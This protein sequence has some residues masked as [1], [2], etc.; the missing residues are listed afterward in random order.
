LT[1]FA[2]LGLF[3]LFEDALDRGGRRRWALAGAGLGVALLLQTTFILFGLVALALLLWRSRPR[4]REALRPA[5]VAAGV[6]LLCLTPAF[7]RNVAVG[8]PVFGLSAVGPVTFIASNVPGYDPA[9][10]FT[11]DERAVA[12]IMGDTGGGFGGVVREVLSDHSPGSFLGLLAGK[13]TVLWHAHE[14]PNNKNFL[15]YRK[16]APILGSAFVTFLVIAPLAAAGLVA[17]GREGSRHALLYGLAG[18][19]AA[20]LLIFYVLSRFRAPFAMALIPFAALALVRMAEWVLEKRWKPAV[21]AS[22]GILVMV[23]WVARPLPANQLTIRS[24]DYRVAYLTYWQPREREA[25]ARSDWNAAAAVLEE[26]LA[27]EPDEVRRIDGTPIPEGRIELRRVAAWFEVL[28]GFRADLLGRAGRAEEAKA[29][30]KRA[31]I[32]KR[33][34]E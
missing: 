5:A 14:L 11:I 20:P 28:H 22:V 8:A 13:F 27:E 9:N 16:H 17:A 3:L 26:A 31:E 18:A 30:S 33:S 23:L 2:A 32:L 1:V 15:Y 12:R 29:E 21:L 25:V 10:G 4:W 7:A 34:R 19:V 6:A 24:A